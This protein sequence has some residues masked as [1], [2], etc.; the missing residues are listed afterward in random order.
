MAPTSA[1]SSRR[2]CISSGPSRGDAWRRRS[3]AVALSALDLKLQQLESPEEEPQTLENKS[4][5][6]E[7][8][9]FDRPQDAVFTAFQHMEF[10]E[11]DEDSES[12]YAPSADEEQEQSESEGLLSSADSE[13]ELQEPNDDRRWWESS[14]D[15]RQWVQQYKQRDATFKREKPV[16]EVLTL[17]R[18]WTLRR[19]TYEAVDDENNGG[20]LKPDVS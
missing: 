20:Q 3:S 4:L 2:R 17:Q 14:Q 9:D 15:K 18:K 16:L 19:L 5:I 13:E 7:N 1:T 6:H 12:D 8:E 10:P 11:S